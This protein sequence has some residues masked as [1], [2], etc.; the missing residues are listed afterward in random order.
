MKHQISSK[1]WKWHYR[2]DNFYLIYKWKRHQKA[3]FIRY[4]STKKQTRW[5]AVLNSPRQDLTEYSRLSDTH[6]CRIHPAT[7]HTQCYGDQTA[8]FGYLVQLII[9]GL[10]RTTA[11]CGGQIKQ[12]HTWPPF[13]RSEQMTQDLTAQLKNHLHMP[14][15]LN[16]TQINRV[17]SSSLQQ[18]ETVWHFSPLSAWHSDSSPA[19]IC[20]PVLPEWTNT[21]DWQ[22]CWE[23]NIP[24]RL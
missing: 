11:W 7:D 12:S 2:Y 16:I 6:C 20:T 22:H 19:L 8:P 4:R 14:A 1:S 21:F 13:C 9:Q 24:N 23:A 10:L 18:T 17:Q 5:I 3:V 15:P